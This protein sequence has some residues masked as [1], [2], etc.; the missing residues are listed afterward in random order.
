[1]PLVAI[2]W[3]AAATL[4]PSAPARVGGT[5]TEPRRVK[6]VDPEYPPDA[7]R[8]GLAGPVVL[9]CLIGTQG[10]VVRADVLEGVPLLADAAA[11]AA[12]RW[13]YTPTLV[14]GM[15]TPVVMKVTVNFRMEELRYRDLL[16]SLDHRDDSIREAA[17]RNLGK[18]HGG[19]GIDGRKIKGGIRA[20]EG[21]AEKDAS[22]RVRAAAARSL[23]RLDGRPLPPGVPAV[24]PSRVH[25]GRPVSF[26]VFID[27]LLSSTIVESDGRV[28]LDLTPGNLDLRVEIGSMSAPRVLRPIEG[29]FEAEVTVGRLPD[30]G[31]PSPG[32]PAVF[33]GAGLL[34]WQ[35]DDNY[36]RLESVA[37]RVASSVEPGQ[38][39][40]PIG[41]PYH[42]AL[43]KVRQDG[44]PLDGPS[45]ADVRLED[46]PADL[47]LRRRG[48]E[49]TAFA[50]QGG[51][52][53]REVGTFEVDFAP[54]LQVGLAALNVARYGMKVAFEGFRL[55]PGAEAARVA[56]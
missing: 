28:E 44:R 39:R 24:D 46:G 26:G 34:L 19:T 5:I 56:E 27:P 18:M 23:T 25:R 17:A 35:D 54:A 20:L 30:I 12:R 55:A 31:I 32:T 6:H 42:Y 3:A 13:R 40:T 48:R 41:A 29:D 7:S 49:F 43:F 53:W 38:R 1:M 36:V 22:P 47:R 10:E 16:D 50:R 52:E 21:L 37:Y 15:A 51:R 2:L 45:R 14:D 8:A 33:R 4:A 11:A 9:E